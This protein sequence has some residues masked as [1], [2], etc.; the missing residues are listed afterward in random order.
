MPKLRF[1]SPD[2]VYIPEGTFC[3]GSDQGRTDETPVHEVWVDAFSIA[4]YPV[5][6]REYAVFLQ[7]TG[8]A[9][10][11]FWSLP[12]FEQPDQPVVGVSWP[13]ATTY[14]A[15]LSEMTG[16]ICRLPTE[17]E[18]EKAARGGLEG[19]AYPWGNEL[20][21]DH[22]GGRDTPLA[23]VGSEGPNGYGLCDMSAGVHEWCADYYNPTYYAVSSSRNPKGSEYGARYVARGGA[24]RH[25]IRFSRCAAR[26]S[27]A[28]EKQFSD[29]GFRCAMTRR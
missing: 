21:D 28:P 2:M 14:C 9:P 12:E 18:R 29:F 26:S 13:E 11:R 7:M 25:N 24:W 5:T 6:R 20:P 15:W 16:H 22:G 19:A 4:R 8:L 17:A 10:P 1:L 27:L 3:M 23:P